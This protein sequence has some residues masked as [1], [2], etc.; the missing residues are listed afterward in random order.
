MK[1]LID[2]TKELFSKSKWLLF[3]VCFLLVRLI[4]NFDKFITFRELEQ[5]AGNSNFFNYFGSYFLYHG[6][7]PLMAVINSFFLFIFRNNIYLV[8]QIV[9]K[10]PILFYLP[11]F[12]SF[13]SRFSKRYEFKILT[14]ILFLA[15]AVVFA[16]YDSLSIF[17]WL[18]IL[19]TLHFNFVYDFIY[20]YQ[21]KSSRGII[22]TSIILFFVHPLSLVYLASAFLLLY[23]Y[24]KSKLSRYFKFKYLLWPVLLWLGYL[25]FLAV[26]LLVNQNQAEMMSLYFKI[27]EQQNIPGFIFFYFKTLALNLSVLL[28]GHFIVDNVYLIIFGFG[29]FIFLAKKYVTQ[30]KVIKDYLKYLVYFWLLILLVIQSMH[31]YRKIDLDCLV[32]YLISFLPFLLVIIASVLSRMGKFLKYT[33]L[34]I[35]VIVNLFYG[36][37][38]RKNGLHYDFIKMQI[39]KYQNLHRQIILEPFFILYDYQ[40]LTGQKLFLAQSNLNLRENYCLILLQYYEFGIPLFNLERIGNYYISR[41]HNIGYSTTAAEEN[42]AYKVFLTQRK[43]R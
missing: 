40:R 12:I 33:L 10:L 21:A 18:L 15:N 11:I 13:C 26:R 23:K 1:G 19:V 35:L 36:Y 29:V 32:T 6:Y 31:F 25:L 2:F 38:L 14:L 22:V 17:F 43:N 20:K 5:I 7:F 28:I 3:I 30:D 16:S 39:A 34:L 37:Q 8:K 24:C 41:F 9:Y 42:S 27:I 4:F